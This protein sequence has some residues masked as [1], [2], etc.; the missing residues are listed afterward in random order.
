MSKHYPNLAV[1]PS[2]P[3]NFTLRTFRVSAIFKI[4]SCREARQLHGPK[5]G[6]KAQKLRIESVWIGLHILV[7][8]IAL[9]SS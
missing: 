1:K 3:L 6:I 8:A 4:I 5:H 9:D 7:W 2:S